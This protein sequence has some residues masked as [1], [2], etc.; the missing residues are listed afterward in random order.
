MTTMAMSLA[1]CKGVASTSIS[2]SVIQ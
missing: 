2:A 1:C